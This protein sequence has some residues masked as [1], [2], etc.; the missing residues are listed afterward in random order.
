[1]LS[2]HGFQQTS[3]GGVDGGSLGGG[4]GDGDGSLN[5][6]QQPGPPVQSH[7][8]CRRWKQPKAL[9]RSSHVRPRQGLER[10]E[11]GGDGGEGGGRVVRWRTTLSRI[12]AV[13]A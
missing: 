3:G 8:A 2:P 6:P 9:I 13:I 1:M 5:L 4:G 11:G 10:Q 7:P 12:M